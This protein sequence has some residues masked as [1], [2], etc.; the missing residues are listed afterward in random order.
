MIGLRSITQLPTPAG[1]RNNFSNVSSSPS[2]HYFSLAHSLAADSRERTCSCALVISARQRDRNGF[3][4]FVNRFRG[5]DS[6]HSC[7]SFSVLP[8]Q[9]FCFSPSNPISVSYHVSVSFYLVRW[10]WVDLMPQTRSFSFD[11]FRRFI[12]E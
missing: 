2:G 12:C 5:L 4:G 9:R 10:I 7:S 6:V 11:S 3:C 1:V 8:C